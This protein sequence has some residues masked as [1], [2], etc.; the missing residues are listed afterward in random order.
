MYPINKF[1]TQPENSSIFAN[2]RIP[3]VSYE[4]FRHHVKAEAPRRIPAMAEEVVGRDRDSVVCAIEN[5]S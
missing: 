4:Y 5:T 2:Q 3:T 1:Q